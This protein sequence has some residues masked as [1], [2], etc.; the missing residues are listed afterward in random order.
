MDNYLWFTSAA[1]FYIPVVSTFNLLSLTFCPWKITSYFLCLN[2]WAWKIRILILPRQTVNRDRWT[3][4]HS[5]S[6]SF[7]LNFFSSILEPV[8]L[9]LLLKTHKTFNSYKMTFYTCE[10]NTTNI[11]E[12]VFYPVKLTPL[13][14]NDIYSST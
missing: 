14:E 6:L 5:L 9:L 12:R 2:L 8:T 11:N 10:W 1:S 13:S 4:N 3:E 7:S